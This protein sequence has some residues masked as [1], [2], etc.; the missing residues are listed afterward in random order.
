M[1]ELRG[2][3]GSLVLIFAA[4]FELSHVNVVVALLILIE[5]KAY[6]DHR[7]AALLLILLLCI[8]HFVYFY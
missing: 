4:H 1:A 5:R 7:W 2:H 6:I 8:H 3:D